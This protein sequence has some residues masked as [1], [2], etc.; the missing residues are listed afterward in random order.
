MKP[1]MG[2]F[3]SYAVGPLPR[4]TGIVAQ[5]LVARHR[6]TTHPHRLTVGSGGGGAFSTITATTKSFPPLSLRDNKD[7]LEEA[8]PEQRPGKYSRPSRS[9]TNPVALL[10]SLQSLRIVDAEQRK[11]QLFTISDFRHAAQILTS[12]LDTLSKNTDGANRLSTSLRIQLI[13]ASFDSVQ[14]IAQELVALNNCTN[15]ILHVRQRQEYHSLAQW[16]FAPSRFLNP[17]LAQWHNVA[18]MTT[19]NTRHASFRNQPTDT[20]RHDQPRPPQPHSV[21][22]YSALELRTAWQALARSLPHFRYDIGAM[23]VLLNVAMKHAPL[24]ATAAQAAQEMLD[25]CQ[26]ESMHLGYAPLR[27]DTFT[28]STVL[29]AWAQPHL[30]SDS[31]VPQRLQNLV[32]DM[33]HHGV[34]L[35]T[36][37]YGILLRYW[38]RRGSVAQIEY[39]LDDMTA[40]GVEPTLSCLAQALFGYARANQLPMARGILDIMLQQYQTSTTQW[41]EDQPAIAATGPNRDR[42]SAPLLDQDMDES[43]LMV[44][45][46]QTILDSLR[47]GILL[48]SKPTDLLVAVVP[49]SKQDG[50]DEM[51]DRAVTEAE[52]VVEQMV[53][54]GLCPP[55]ST[56]HGT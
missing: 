27:P 28:Y 51:V 1:S 16:F 5:L 44:A 36:V 25:F 56:S 9:T 23:G 4:T 8:L 52:A 10:N 45:S 43:V 48:K 42:R 26:S 49:L 55:A 35:N 24:A 53:A 47:Q 34:P 21:T 18:S 14:R 41:N 30:E 15:S 19:T 38:A 6:P 37:V 31:S 33:K 11:Q 17:L 29:H 12:A 39:W 2:R 50:R 32:K 46:A 40:H 3:A 54:S 13:N 22:L 7:S 20:E